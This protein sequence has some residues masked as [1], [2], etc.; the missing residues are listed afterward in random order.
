MRGNCVKLFQNLCTS[1][2]HPDLIV[3][4]VQGH[5][6]V[7]LSHSVQTCCHCQAPCNHVTL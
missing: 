7:Y 6:R 1:M 4:E 2:E 3:H 5:G